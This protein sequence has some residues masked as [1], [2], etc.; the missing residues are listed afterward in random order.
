[1][2]SPAPTS[3]RTAAGRP[4]DLAPIDQRCQ[5]ATQGHEGDVA[6]VPALEVRACRIAELRR[7]P[8]RRLV[9]RGLVGRQARLRWKTELSL[10]QFEVVAETLLE[11]DEE[12][13]RQARAK[14]VLVPEPVPVG[15]V[16]VPDAAHRPLGLLALL[17]TG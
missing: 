16:Q 4:G 5:L 6:R 1:R 13:I 3:S 9:S 14:R 2:M 15:R 10:Q 17:A 7:V 8:G 12:E 11:R